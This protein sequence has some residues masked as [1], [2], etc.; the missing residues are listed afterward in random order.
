MTDAPK[1][2]G[3]PTATSASQRKKKFYHTTE[4]LSR[5]GTNG[6]TK[7]HGDSIVYIDGKPYSLQ[8]LSKQHNLAVHRLSNRILKWRKAGKSFT[9][10]DLTKP[11]QTR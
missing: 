6:N 11:L 7:R 8:V 5:A 2:R 4:E 10:E 3:L 1:P 9:L